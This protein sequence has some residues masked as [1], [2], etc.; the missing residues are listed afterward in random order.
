MCVLPPE[1][2]HHTHPIWFDVS[3]MLRGPEQAGVDEMK[4]MGQLL[5]KMSQR[6]LAGEQY[7]FINHQYKMEKSLRGNSKQAKRH[8]REHLSNED[9]PSVRIVSRTNRGLEVK[10]TF[11]VLDMAEVTCSWSIG[12]HSSRCGTSLT[13]YVLKRIPPQ[14]SSTTITGGH[15]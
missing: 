13:V 15:S 4:M 14:V 10:R 7:R 11:L 8:S 6:D 3:R 2:A 9:A 12:N 5:H 1:R